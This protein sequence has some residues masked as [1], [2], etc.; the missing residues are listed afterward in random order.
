MA[1]SLTLNEPIRSK[2]GWETGWTSPPRWGRRARLL[3]GRADPTP[4]RIRACAARLVRLADGQPD[5]RIVI[6]NG[7]GM[8]RD[9][10]SVQAVLQETGGAVGVL[11]DLGNWRGPHK[12]AELARIAP[13][14][15]SCHA[16]CRFTGAAPD[17]EDFR[18]ALQI[19]QDAGFHGPLALIY[20]GADD[21]EWA[22]L[23]VE[24]ALV[25]GVFG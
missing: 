18:R 9:A 20:D 12:D 17:A 24:D 22:K 2:P 23:E 16:K 21:D 15:E 1:I 14:A 25:R 13:C 10:P 19:L 5:V 6:E 4:G 7:G 3:V 8:L 11:I